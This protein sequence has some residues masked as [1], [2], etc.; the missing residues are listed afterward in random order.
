MTL[1][2]PQTEWWKMWSRTSSAIWTWRPWGGPS[3][4]A[5]SG[6]TSFRPAPIFGGF[7]FCKIICKQ[8][9]LSTDC[10][11][12]ISSD[13]IL[14][15]CFLLKVDL[16]GPSWPLVV[17]NVNQLLFFFLSRQ[18]MDTTS[19]WRRMAHFAGLDWRVRRDARYHRRLYAALTRSHQVT[20]KSLN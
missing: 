17:E 5:A 13:L 9:V 15:F 20:R 1:P 12:K 7:F 10:S 8:I 19:S 2:K 18:K 16:L 3:R 14:H 11:L 4:S 6:T